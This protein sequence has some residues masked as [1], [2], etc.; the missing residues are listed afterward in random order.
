[1][2]TRKDR[3]EESAM[4][5]FI[6]AFVDAYFTNMRADQF[7]FLDEVY[8]TFAIR[9]SEISEIMTVDLDYIDNYTIVKSDV[10]R[11]MFDK[12]RL[13][14]DLSYRMI[15][16]SFDRMNEVANNLLE[17]SESLAAAITVCDDLVKA[18]EGSLKRKVSVNSIK[19]ELLYYDTIGSET[20]LMEGSLSVDRRAGVATLG[21]TGTVP[22]DF[23]IVDAVSNAVIFSTWIVFAE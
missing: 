19:D 22:V 5:V 13:A 16:E 15:P 4:E 20:L 3:R 21:V 17:K 12:A 2:L 18:L 7:T 10:Y 14:A 9:T 11:M 1:M 23:T 8:R 6:N